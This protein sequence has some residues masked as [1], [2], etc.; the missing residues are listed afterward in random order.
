MKALVFAGCESAVK[1]TGWATVEVGKGEPR[2]G[3]SQATAGK[4]EGRPGTGA[5]GKAGRIHAQNRPGQRK[6][7]PPKSQL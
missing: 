5:A 1:W 2:L 4:G 7:P 3:C 6:L